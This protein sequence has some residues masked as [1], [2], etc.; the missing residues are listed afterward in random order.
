MLKKT[1]I[2]IISSLLYLSS[3]TSWASCSLYN[4][5]G[6]VASMKS[7]TMPI[8]GVIS[9]PPDVPVGNEIYRLKVELTDQESIYVACTSPGQFYTGYKYGTTPLL[10][11]AYSNTVYKTGVPGIGVKFIR[12]NSA[13][14]F[15][16]TLVTSGCTGTGCVFN[17]G[18]NADS[19]LVFIKTAST[20]TGGVIDASQLPTALY[21]FGQTSS[22]I[23]VYKITLTGSLQINTPTCDIST[24]SQAMAVNMGNYHISAFSGKGSATGWKNASIQLANCGQFY[25]NV[26]SGYT[27]GTFN[28]TTTST[29][30]TRNNFLSVTLY[31]QNGTRSTTDAANGIMKIDDGTPG[32]TGVGI[33]LSSSESTSGLIDLTTGIT[34]ILP[35]DGTRNITVPLYARYIQTENSVTAGKANGRLEYVITYQ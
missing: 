26:T 22:M 9:V 8:N 24:V 25:G 11:T 30:A 35:K 7:L 29:A 10:P 6:Y 12:N 23:D 33:Q 19:R 14:N 3:P 2:I 21:S 13:A 20:V 32:A 5:P 16:T 34:Q 1:F 4:G 15:P 27:G 28:G 17:S 18:W 31:P